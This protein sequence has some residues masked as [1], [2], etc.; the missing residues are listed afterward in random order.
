VTSNIPDPC[1]CRW[2]RIVETLPHMVLTATPDGAV[3]YV[4]PQIA[5]YAGLPMS[6]L[7]GSGW[8]E[9]VHPED[10]ATSI[11]DWNESVHTGKDFHAEHRLRRSDGEYRWFS[12]DARP[13]RDESGRID[14]WTATCCEIAPPEDFERALH[15]S[16]ERF[17][18]T[19]ENA[20]VGMILT[21]A[22]GHLLALNAR[23]CEFLGYSRQELAGRRLAE[24]VSA[25]DVA[26]ALD[27]WQQVVRGEIPSL[28]RDKRYF[29]KD[30]VVVWGTI[31]FSVIQRHADGTAARLMAIVQDITA[32]KSLEVALQK[33]HE[34]FELALRGSDVA[35]FAAEFPD[36]NLAHSRW[37][38]FNMWERLGF[39]PASAPTDFEGV[40]ALAIHPADQRAV[41]A[42]MEALVRARSSNSYSEHRV[43]HRDGS[44]HWALKRGTIVYDEAGTP[45]SF[46]GT[47]ADITKL[48]LVE[49][50]LS[51]AREA[52]EAANR[53]KD[54][55]LAN[56]SHEIRTPMNAILGMTELALDSAP[57]DYQRQLLSTVRS[58]AKN[59]LGIINDLLDFSKIAA[60]RLTLDRADFSLRAA[61]GDT[62]RALAVRAHRKGLE[63][64]CRVR[65]D[66]PDALYGDAG[67]LRQVL[68][69]LVGNAIKFT[70]RGEVEVE[71]AT[72]A[73]PNERTVALVF[74]VRDTGIGIA[75]EKQ[76]AIFRAFEQGDSSTTRKYGGTGLGLT[77]SAQLAALMDGAIT[78]HSE[79]GR[80][81]TFRFSARFAR[82]SL[83]E[84][85]TASPERLAGL[86]VL[87]VDDNEA[88]RHIL[89]E[90]LTDWRMRPTAVG[91]AS[92]VLAALAHADEVGEPFSLVILD[93]RMPDGDGITLAAQ[94]RRRY[95]TS[96]PR[97]ILLSSDDTAA[98]P[99]RSRENGILAYLLK[100]VQ[101][102][103]LLE[104][105]WAAMSLDV[106]APSALAKTGPQPQALASLRV[107]VAEDNELNIGLLRELLRKRGHEP[108]F[109]RDGRAALEL[110]L[111]GTS[112]L[113]LLDLHMPEM[114]GFDVVH[115]IRERERETGQHLPIIALTARSSA[116]DRERCLAA[117]MDEFM[118]KP[119][120]AAELWSAIDRLAARV[121]PATGRVA[122]SVDQG[123]LDA[124]VILRA[125]GGDA[126]LLQKLRLVFRQ[127]LPE[128]VARIGAALAER[129]LRQ[130]REAAHKLVGTVGAFSTVT[131]DL[132]VTLEAAAIG[133]DLDSC[134]PLVERLV[135]MCERL[136][137][138]T[139][140]LS[141]DSLAL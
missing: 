90:W 50:E 68:L 93:G 124:R 125:C 102:S 95:G 97:Q 137:D 43:L 69:N 135:R 33:A 53:A 123:L 2:Q 62:L 86:R 126:E 118:S 48:K 27:Q 109:A 85:A 139:V 26:A 24:F 105:I 91:D 98:L 32:R 9:I 121:A 45:T 136:L 75:R 40:K 81:S 89:E 77:I 31:T 106:T 56:V 100:P 82:S 21:D 115:A 108:R 111:Q 87:V 96:A 16:E 54:E 116:R 112:D 38:F 52:A 128:H 83:P 18:H 20:A 70:P 103:E 67:R 79:P 138:A 6:A 119:I 127:R 46:I 104:A 3:D 80:G 41:L 22:D 51:R 4:S 140:T 15:E 36:G 94:I 73:A 13:V 1:D 132:A 130:L 35:V 11:R 28:T 55:F 72:D 29:R 78:V 63:L 120:E 60:G 92:S 19:F 71:V 74:T 39:D 76:A 61:T 12:C 25:D 7:V 133:E 64:L 66:V 8:L 44:V 113:L 65:P 122:A 101:Q 10:R 88:N 117:G 58:S 110:A 30:G 129:N 59:L 23:F 47:Y 131:A 17:R 134:G 57:S 34:R 37:T 141:L 14:M 107:L 114:D 5:T 84:V 42:H 49:A 99:A